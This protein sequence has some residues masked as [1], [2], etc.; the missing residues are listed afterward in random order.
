MIDVIVSLTVFHFRTGAG[1]ALILT[2]KGGYRLLMKCKSFA[3]AFIIQ[4]CGND[5]QLD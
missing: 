5:R 3:D 2:L 4:T 1:E